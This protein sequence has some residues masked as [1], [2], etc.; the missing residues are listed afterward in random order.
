MVGRAPLWHASS[1]VALAAWAGLGDDAASL[2]TAAAE[3]PAAPL[4]ADPPLGASPSYAQLFDLALR[5]ATLDPSRRLGAADAL[6]SHAALALPCGGQQP[7]WEPRLRAA[8]QPLVDLSEAV[9]AATSAAARRVDSSGRG[10]FRQGIGGALA[11]GRLFG[12]G[13]SPSGG[14]SSL[15][16]GG[17]PAPRGMFAE[18]SP[19]PGDAA[20]APDL[21]RLRPPPSMAGTSAQALLGGKGRLEFGSPS[22]C[23]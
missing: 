14:R 11:G 21:P 7:Q 2:E 22:P 15:G 18:A 16:G 8:L 5:L 20:G 4:A 9:A 19:G 12:S 6:R 10:G 23:G 13:P 17:R 3:L 1:V